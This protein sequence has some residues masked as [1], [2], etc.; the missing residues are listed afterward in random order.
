[1]RGVLGSSLITLLQSPLVKEFYCLFELDT[2]KTCWLFFYWS[3]LHARMCLLE[4]GDI[5]M[6]GV[7]DG[8]QGKRDGV[9]KALR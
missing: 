4:S 3:T 6:P 1:V 9:V 2:T 8:R 5:I 7:V